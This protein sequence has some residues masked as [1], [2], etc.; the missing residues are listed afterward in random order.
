[1]ATRRHRA[2][3]LAAGL[4]A[5][6][7]W[8]G[9]GSQLL[10]LPFLP[11]ATLVL[12]GRC[13]LAWRW[14]A[15]GV[16]V[17][18]IAVSPHWFSMARAYGNPLHSTQTYA[19]GFFGLADDQWEDWRRRFFAVYWNHNLPSP[20]DRFRDGERFRNSAL[21][22]SRVFAC[23]FLLGPDANENQ[24]ALLGRIGESI[25]LSL[26]T[27][28]ERETL[29]DARGRENAAR[30][31]RPLPLVASPAS[32]PAWHFSLPQ[33]LGV[34]G[35]LAAT[36]SW[37]PATALLASRRRRQDDR[38]DNQGGDPPEWKRHLDA[39][40]V[41]FALLA[42]EAAF[43]I[44][45]WRAMR[46]LTFVTVPLALVLGFLVPVFLWSALSALLGRGRTGCMKTSDPSGRAL[47]CILLCLVVFNVWVVSSVRVTTF[48]AG[49][50]MRQAKS[51]GDGVWTAELAREIEKTLPNDAVIMISDP[52]ELC[53]YLPSTY[54]A[55][56][57]PFAPL[58]VVLGVAR[59]YGVTHVVLNHELLEL[60]A[61]VA[62]RHP[63]LRLAI[64]GDDRVYAVDFAQFRDGEI[65]DPARWTAAHL[66]W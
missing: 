25:K 64:P 43:V 26:S 5:A 66:P 23:T 45:F 54:R 16:G 52:W 33:V 34:L 22:N 3:F 12:H 63:A 59:Y 37:L 18:L 29:L 51:S 46:R 13:R 20:T 40:T 17:F 38:G 21:R 11:M 55:V 1:L 14:L 48:Q 28:A 9:K 31:R 24:F 42:S 53:F 6:L 2:W 47:G 50:Y 39:G 41:L 58:P 61:M 4:L 56:M 30:A 35:G 57:L 27:P 36:L 32:W 60:R 15:G 19:A 8:Y 62:A 49:Q 44:V 7:A 10:L 65:E